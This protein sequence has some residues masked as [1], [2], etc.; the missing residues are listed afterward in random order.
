MKKKK[1]E[2]W[3]SLHYTIVL[4]PPNEVE[5]LFSWNKGDGF[6]RARLVK[7]VRLPRDSFLLRHI[8][9]YRSRIFC[10]V[11]KH[12]RLFERFFFFFF[13]ASFRGIFDAFSAV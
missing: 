11:T 9:Q 10:S 7:H 2:R 13:A 1:R 3:R 6:R 12:P 8:L 5:Y 4:F